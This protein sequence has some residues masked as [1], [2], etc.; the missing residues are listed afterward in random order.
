MH[1]EQHKM[2]FS[3]LIKIR[4]CC[5]RLTRQRRKKLFYVLFMKHLHDNKILKNEYI[6]TSTKTSKIMLHA[7]ICQ[8]DIYEILDAHSI[9]LRTIFQRINVMSSFRVIVYVN[10]IFLAILQLTIVLSQCIFI[11][12]IYI[13]I[14]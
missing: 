13:N 2:L 10:I 3:Y 8:C 14:H 4:C 6:K 7:T 11:Q 1:R 12:Y 5:F 9:L